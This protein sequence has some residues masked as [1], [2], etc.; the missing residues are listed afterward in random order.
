L[1]YSGPVSI[2]TGDAHFLSLSGEYHRGLDYLSRRYGFEIPNYPID[3]LVAFSN[4]G[5]VEFKILEMKYSPR[6]TKIEFSQM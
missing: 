2:L 3:V 6:L 4:A 1:A 5:K